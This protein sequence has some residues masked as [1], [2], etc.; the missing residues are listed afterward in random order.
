MHTLK[1]IMDLFKALDIQYG[2]IEHPPEGRTDLASK[3]RGHALHQAAKAMVIQVM[4]A[5]A[6]ARYVLAVV[7]GDSKVDFKAIAKLF[8]V[9]KVKLATA[10]TAKELTGCE[11]GAIPPLS[12]DA[13]LFLLVDSTLRLAGTLFF[14][15]GRLDTS[16][17]ISAED[18]FQMVG[19]AYVG[20]I[21]TADITYS[22]PTDGDTRDITGVST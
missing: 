10:E 11:M 17:S 1:K 7:A 18:Y 14:N 19:N 13:R 21:S 2:L 22:S 15:A 6:P 12:F 4:P 5:Y 3:I 16:F 9:K 8:N 20:K